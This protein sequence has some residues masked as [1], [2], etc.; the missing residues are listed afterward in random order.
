MRDSGEACQLYQEL[1]E[2]QRLVVLK[3]TVTKGRQIY[4]MIINFHKVNDSQEVV[5]VVEH[6]EG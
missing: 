1:L 5:I 3:H 4:W 2:H 6:L